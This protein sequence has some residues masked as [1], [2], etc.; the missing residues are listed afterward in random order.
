MILNFL[1]AH[2]N[3]LIGPLH[4]R[5]DGSVGPVPYKSR[6]LILCG[7]AAGGVP[8]PHALNVP[9]KDSLFT[10]LFH[11]ISRT[12]YNA[13]LSASYHRVKNANLLPV[14]FVAFDKCQMVR[15]NLVEVMRR[16]SVKDDS[17]AN[18]K[19]ADVDGPVVFGGDLPDGKE[20]HA[21]LV[22]QIPVALGNQLRDFFAGGII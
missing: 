17:E 14:L 5:L 13:I 22:F 9:P 6:Q 11:A 19:V 15:G 3:R 2:R 8:K 20:L 16:N 7:D 10:H 4:Q 18:L 21:G 12:L 1:D